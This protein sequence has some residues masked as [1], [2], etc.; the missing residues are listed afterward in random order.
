MQNFEQKKTKLTQKQR[1]KQLAVTVL[2]FSAF[3]HESGGVKLCWT[4][5]VVAALYTIHQQ[6]TIMS[7]IYIVFSFTGRPISFACL[8]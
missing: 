4:F 8:S 7:Y 5:V 6:T 1:Y 3:V 2:L